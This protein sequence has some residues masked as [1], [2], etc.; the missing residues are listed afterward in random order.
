MDTRTKRVGEPETGPGTGSDETPYDSI[1]SSFLPQIR[2]LLAEATAEE[3]AAPPLPVGVDGAAPESPAGHDTASPVGTSPEAVA[4]VTAE[5]APDAGGWPRTFGGYELLERIAGGAVGVVYKARQRQ[6]ERIVAVKV[7]HSGRDASAEEIERFRREAQAAAG[8]QHPHIVRVLEVGEFAGQV[9]FS[10]DYIAGRSLADRVRHSPLP[11]AQAADCLA[12]VARAIQFAHRHGVLHRDLKP[13]NILLDAD[14][15]PHVVDF[16]LAR[17]VAE[18]RLTATGVTLGT[19]SYMPP[20]QAAGRTADIGPASDVYSLG[21]TLYELLTGRPPFLADTVWGTLQQAVHNEPAGPRSI[22][23]DLDRNLETIC[24]KCLRKEPSQRYATA[25]SLADD[26]GRW[27]RGEPILARPAGSAERAVRWARRN[28]RVA[29]L[30]AAVFLS[31]A[32]ATLA[33]AVG[34][35]AVTRAHRQSQENLAHAQRL[36]GSALCEKAETDTGLTVL[37]QAYRTAESDSPARQTALRL[38]AGWSHQ[39]GACLP[40]DE[41]VVLLTAGEHAVTGFGVVHRWPL[42]RPWP[43][44]PEQVRLRVEVQTG[45]D[46]D[47]ATHSVRR[48]SVAEWER[49]RTLAE[50]RP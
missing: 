30:I 49:R 28:P 41:R 21:A 11:P 26:L 20:E 16:G 23:P 46:W 18:P 34:M 4:A 3:S 47:E 9:F 29:G 17:R 13:S 10:M 19:P 31:L 44:D 40:H 12:T 50:P 2:D 27:R 37:H 15:Q 42:P 38:L 39:L 8:L 5:A 35:L 24:L 36:L 6:P 14:G 7:L 45:C 25:E 43:D 48:L 22:N 32:F 1:D 33:S